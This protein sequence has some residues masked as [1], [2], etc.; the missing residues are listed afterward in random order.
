MGV[1]TLEYFGGLNG[2]LG[3]DLGLWRSVCEELRPGRPRAQAL[4]ETAAG[5]AAEAATVRVRYSSAAPAPK[6]AR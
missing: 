2:A 3:P 5:T 1:G 4:G 6:V